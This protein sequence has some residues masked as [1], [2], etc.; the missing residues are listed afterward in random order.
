M[1][2]VA[3]SP[4]E[5]RVHVDGAGDRGARQNHRSAAHRDV[6]GHRSTLSDAAPT[7]ADDPLFAAKMAEASIRIDALE[8]Y[9]LRAMSQLARGGS[10]GLAASV[11]KIVGTKLEQRVTEPALEA[12]GRPVSAGMLDALAASTATQFAHDLLFDRRFVPASVH[13]RRATAAALHRG[14]DRG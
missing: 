13:R 11:M 2:A 1:N 3:S 6:R 8:M 5:L 7:L 12:A 4:A 9:E 14:R 10:P